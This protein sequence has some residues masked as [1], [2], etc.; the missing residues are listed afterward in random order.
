MS[1]S[2]YLSTQAAAVESHCE[3]NYIDGGESA[4][5][6]FI[7]L[8]LWNG[9]FGRSPEC[10]SYASLLKNGG[11]IDLSACPKTESAPF[12]KVNE[13]FGTMVPDP[14][15]WPVNRSKTESACCGQCGSIGGEVRIHYF[16]TEISNHS[17]PMFQDFKNANYTINRRDDADQLEESDNKRSSRTGQS[18][19]YRVATYM[20]NVM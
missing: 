5:V 15:I 1:C 16:P 7:A 17:N 13:A 9:L 12:L 2:S 18:K 19:R 4:D 14:M 6:R 3:C 10:K 11:S 20:G 8:I